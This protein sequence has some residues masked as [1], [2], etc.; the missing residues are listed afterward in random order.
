MKIDDYALTKKRKINIF[1][2]VWFQFGNKSST[3]QRLKI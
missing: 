3:L 2:E 1:E